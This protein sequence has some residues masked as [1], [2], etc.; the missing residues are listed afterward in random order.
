MSARM[1]M[2]KK[3][4]LISFI[5]FFI[6]QIIKLLI[7][8]FIGLNNSI[9]IIPGFFSFTYIIN[10][11]AAWNILN[12]HQIL[13]ILLSIII[14]IVI[15]LFMKTFKLNKRNIWAFG[16]LY[17]GIVGNL[18][19]RLFHGYVIDYLDFNLFNYPVFN[20]ADMSIVI[21]VILLIIGII[22]GED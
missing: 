6:D 8:F 20:F 12:N 16:L 13:L 19:D 5:I 18:F 3:I 15:L 4:F 9:S 7:S 10:Y 11:G 2:K 17:G 21:G 1:F 22:K 14:I